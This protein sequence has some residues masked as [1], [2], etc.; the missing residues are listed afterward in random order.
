M[1]KSFLL[2]WL[3]ACFSLMLTVKIVPGLQVSR[4]LVFLL[5]S[6]VIGL[7]NSFLRPV[8]FL[9]TLP[10]NLA[11]LGLFSLFINAFIFVLAGYMVKGFTVNHFWS[12]FW[13]ALLFSAINALL[14]SLLGSRQV[15]WQ[16]IRQVPQPD[17][18]RKV[19]DLKDYS[20]Q[21]SPEEDTPREN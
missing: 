17:P 9:L 10:I 3:L 15:H 13:G 19:I 14:N 12:A 8:L 2:A 18:D 11:T 6:L 16:I 21:T 5:A 7:L 4:W 20:L 1:R